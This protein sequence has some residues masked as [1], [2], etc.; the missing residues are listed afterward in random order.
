MSPLS[1][2]TS[3]VTVSIGSQLYVCS[4]ALPN[5]ESAPLLWL[6][7]ILWFT[8]CFMSASYASNCNKRSDLKYSELIHS[9]SKH[10][11]IKVLKVC[12]ENVFCLPVSS[13]GSQFQLNVC[14]WKLQE[15]TLQSSLGYMWTADTSHL[16]D[17]SSQWLHTQPVCLLSIVL[18]AGL[19]LPHVLAV[20]LF[21]FICSYLYCQV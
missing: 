21:L 9:F 19:L 2:K 14:F 6:I 15:L 12:C 11:D 5:S 8:V 3:F 7:I 17:H 16:C 20:A 10:P 13:S 1:Y 18:E 4:L